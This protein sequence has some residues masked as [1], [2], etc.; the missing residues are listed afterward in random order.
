MTKAFAGLRIG[1]WYNVT[2]Q[3]YAKTGQQIWVRQIEE[4]RNLLPTRVSDS[5]EV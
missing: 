1:G 4:T 5:V 3:N 2:Y